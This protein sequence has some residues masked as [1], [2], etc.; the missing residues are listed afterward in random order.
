MRAPDDPHVEAAV[1]APPEP[2]SRVVVGHAAYHVLGRHDAVEEGPQAEEPPGKEELRGREGGLEQ[3]QCVLHEDEVE[4]ANGRG[5]PRKGERRAEGG[6]E[7]RRE[8]EQDAP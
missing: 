2:E 8:R 4:C 1:P 5:D 7:R 3:G 6:N